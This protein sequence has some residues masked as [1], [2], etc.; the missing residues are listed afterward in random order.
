MK[1]FKSQEGGQYVHNVLSCVL[2]KFLNN[3]RISRL[4]SRNTNVFI[5]P[6][7]VTV[8]ERFCGTVYQ[9]RRQ[10]FSK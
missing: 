10:K 6:L 1:T 4:N 9:K 3:C 2:N 7:N 8:S 5:A